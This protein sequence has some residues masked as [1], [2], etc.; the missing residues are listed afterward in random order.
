MIFDDHDLRQ[1]N[2]AYI[3]S[4]DIV[5]LEKPASKLLEDLK[6]ARE[7]LN[8][9]PNN[10]SRPPSSTEPWVMADIEDEEETEDEE[11][12]DTAGKESTSGS[13]ESK[14]NQEKKSTEPGKPGKQKGAEG[15]GRTQQLK[16]TGT[17]IHFAEAC[18]VCDRKLSEADFT[19]R[20]GHYVIDIL[21]GDEDQPGITVTN[22]KHLYGDT[23][24]L[25]GHVM[26]SAP[27]RCEKEEDRGV[28]LTEWHLVEEFSKGLTA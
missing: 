28:E 14:E 23:V 12:S 5:T 19:A 22:I 3:K 18:S 6:E 7:R 13:T 15:K 27:H 17:V 21:M 26:H 1:I 11:G 9:N 10:S 8:Q 4:L 2:Q 16:I 25:C 24:C 20:T